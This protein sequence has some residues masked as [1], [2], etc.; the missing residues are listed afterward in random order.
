MLKTLESFGLS[1]V[2]SE[3][4]VYLAKVGPCKAEDLSIGL[5]KT[6]RQ[7]YPA[8][9]ELK[10]K[11]I[12]ASRSEHSALF[13]ALTFEELLTLFMNLNAEKAKAIRETKEELVTNWQK[14][15]KQNNT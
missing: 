8:L 4:Y 10:K 12:V 5:R 7:V 14:M 6:K 11:G 2:E 3:I 1:R 13:S 9:Q 15:T